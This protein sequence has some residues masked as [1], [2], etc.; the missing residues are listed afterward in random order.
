MLDGDENTVSKPWYGVFDGPEDSAL[1]VDVSQDAFTIGAA[2]PN[3]GIVGSNPEPY[4]NPRASAEGKLYRF[5][6]YGDVLSEEEV[7]ANY[8]AGLAALTPQPPAHNRGDVTED[9]FVGADDLVAILTNWG[10]TG[11]VP[12][13]NGDIGRATKLYTSTTSTSARAPTWT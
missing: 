3:P 6:V 9:N 5:L 8:E 2:T 1:Y 13:E 12:W 7:A 10:E 11:D 4:L